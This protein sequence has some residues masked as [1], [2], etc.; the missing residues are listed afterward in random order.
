[1]VSAITTDWDWQNLVAMLAVAAALA[2]V[3]RLGWQSIVARKT[4]ACGGCNRCAAPNASESL[5]IVGL[6]QLAS[7]GDSASRPS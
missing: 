7:P 3:V 4:A 5:P 2:F 6:D 1:M